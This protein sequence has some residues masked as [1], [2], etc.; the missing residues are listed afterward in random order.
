[1]RCPT[2]GRK[3]EKRTSYCL[4]C[5]RTL[6]RGIAIK[7]AVIIPF[8]VVIIGGTY[9][10]IE[11]NA[12]SSHGKQIKESANAAFRSKPVLTK[13]Q[14]G[15]IDSE[16]TIEE[17]IQAVEKNIYAVSASTKEGSAFLYDARGI[18]LTNAHLVEGQL[19][20]QIL[21][22]DKEFTGS[23]IGYSKKANIAAI[24]VP[25]LAG[26]NTYPMEMSKSLAKGDE[27]IAIGSKQVLENN[28]TTATIEE[29]DWHFS[30]GN[31]TYEHTYQLSEP[32]LLQ[33]SGGP[34]I[35]AKTGNIVA[36]NSIDHVQDIAVQFSIPIN[37][38]AN[39]V[40]DWI[41]K[42]MDEATITAQFYGPSGDYFFGELWGKT[43]D[44]E[45]SAA[46]TVESDTVESE[47]LA[48][49]GDQTWNP[50][51]Y[52][53][54]VN[55]NGGS[56]GSNGSQNGSNTNYGF[57]EGSASGSGNTP[58]SGAGNDSEEQ[59]DDDNTSPALPTT[60]DPPEKPEKP[61]ED[62]ESQEDEGP[63]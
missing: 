37:K 8:L 30:Y 24:H 45:S 12:G 49:S 44:Q 21:A 59:G 38:I 39:M 32:L 35:S 54:P 16:K 3:K 2:C 57:G 25:E 17:I 31:Y 40:N 52:T 50:P 63:V 11:N 53:P 48:P 47:N 18:L 22:D 58:N 13:K 33:F 46:D 1:M 28:T 61:K 34:L 26:K 9:L 5:G 41:E 27:V 62:K 19:E 15:S 29:S 4:N 36:V 10:L 55:Q 60:P 42:P 6:K 43:S 20:V 7:L 51:I 23:V 14:L 56:G